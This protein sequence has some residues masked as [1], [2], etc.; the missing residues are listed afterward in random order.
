MRK[1]VF[2]AALLTLLLAVSLWN[3]SY[4]GDF[5]EE[6]HG[7]TAEARALAEVGDFSK[8]AERVVAALGRWQE[9]GG[10]TQMLLRHTEIN[11]ITDAFYARLND[12]YAGDGGKATGNFERL[13]A[14]LVALRDAERLTWGNIF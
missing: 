6:L 11:T 13:D 12:L 9:K 2:A 14:C 1:M 10:Y 4:L 5:V 3:L 7:Y 8:A